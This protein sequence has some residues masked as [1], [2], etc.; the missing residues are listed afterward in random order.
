MEIYHRKVRWLGFIFII[1]VIWFSLTL[2]GYTSQHLDSSETTAA[3][4]V[5]GVCLLV[6]LQCFMGSTRFFFDNEASAG[7][8]IRKHFY[9]EKIVHYPYSN[10]LEVTVRCYRR[11]NKAVPT[12]RVGI[13]EGTKLFGQ[14][15]TQFT[16]LRSFGGTKED[17]F[18]ARDFAKE[19]CLYTTLHFT[20]DSD[21]VRPDVGYHSH[22]NH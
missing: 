14:E 2:T 7:I 8:Q 1:P 19:I 5:I 4:V 20:D 11:G 9:G 6:A 15:A 18:A 17:R 13:T 21:N 22:A 3:Y 12:Y 10:I 16:E